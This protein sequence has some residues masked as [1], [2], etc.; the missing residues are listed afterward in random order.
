[1]N[2]VGRLIIYI[3]VFIYLVGY[4]CKIIYV[5]LQSL[6]YSLHL[7]YFDNHLWL[8]ISSQ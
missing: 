7:S 5:I 6:H 4:F 1:M 2:A 3:V 8:K